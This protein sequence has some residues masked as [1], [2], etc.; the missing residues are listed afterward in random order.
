M[1][2]FI[3][4]SLAQSANTSVPS[5]CICSTSPLP[6]NDNVEKVY[7]YFTVEKGLSAE[8]A[9]GII[10][11]MIHES[12]VEPMR[13]QNEFNR[14][15]SS[16]EAVS[17]AVPGSNLGWGLVQWTPGTKIIQTAVDA[18]I[19]FEE[20]NTLEFQLE[21]LWGQ[22]KGE[23]WRGNPDNVSSEKSAGDIIL[24]STTVEEATI[25]FGK[26]YERFANSNDLN[27]PEYQKRI[28]SAREILQTVTEGGIS[29]GRSCTNGRQAGPN[30]WDLP[31]E[32]PNPMVYFSQRTSGDPV[33]DPAVEGYFGSESYG[34]GPISHC[35]CGPTSWAM[36]VSTLTGKRTEPPE[37]ATWASTNGFQQDGT[38]CGGSAWWWADNTAL[39][40][41]RWGVQ[42]RSI[43]IEEAAMSLRSGALIIVS[44]D[45]GPFTGG[46]HLVV[47][48]AVTPDGRFL[49]ADPNDYNDTRPEADIFNG[50]SKSRVALSPN[51]FMGSVKGLW[52]V[53]AL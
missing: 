34:P 51:D 1:A 7:N 45:A 47:M 20:I 19:P 18:G 13:L 12:R 37:V 52:E 29:T 10:G 36:I 32:G 43:S 21:F 14:L 31:G 25:S 23:A 46:G 40:E 4:N 30:G 53:R 48:R 16:R 26:E 5:D 42:A 24:A 49:F 33:N 2:Q 39:S 3:V 38:P 17:I 44:T 15:V 9:T 35:G 6:G 41:S 50:E 28:D 22:L 11:N 8:I 27:N